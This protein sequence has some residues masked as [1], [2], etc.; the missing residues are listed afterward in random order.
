[1]AEPARRLPAA[2]DADLR[3]AIARLEA[4]LA[5]IEA[6]L[7]RTTGMR[8]E[9]DREFLLAI[10][11]TGAG[12]WWTC[13]ELQRHKRAFPRLRAALRNADAE[14]PRRLGWLCSR[15]EGCDVGGLTVERGRDS[16][17]GL[18]WRARVLRVS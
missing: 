10:A 8:D 5:I 7:A 3:A 18:R 14:T 2:R 6:R 12:A 1:M 16:R 11:E 4:R 9:A 17:D 13:K 15:L